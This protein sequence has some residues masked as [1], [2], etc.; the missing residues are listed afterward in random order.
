MMSNINAS[1]GFPLSNCKCHSYTDGILAIGQH[2][3]CPRSTCTGD[4]SS[5]NILPKPIHLLIHVFES[6]VAL[7]ICFRCH[8]QVVSSPSLPTPITPNPHFSQPPFSRLPFLLSLQ[9]PPQLMLALLFDPPSIGAL[10]ATCAR[11][12]IFDEITTAGVP[13]AGVGQDQGGVPETRTKSEQKKGRLGTKGGETGGRRGGKAHQREQ[14]GKAP[15]GK[16]HPGHAPPGKAHPGRAF[17]AHWVATP[18]F[19]FAL[20]A[21]TDVTAWCRDDEGIY[22]QVRELSTPAPLPHIR[23]IKP[24][25]HTHPNPPEPTRTHPYPLPTSP[26]SH[27]PP[28]IP[29]ATLSPPPGRN[30]CDWR[31][32]PAVPRRRFGDRHVLGLPSRWERRRQ[33]HARDARLPDGVGR[34]APGDAQEPLP[35][36][37]AH[38]LY[39]HPRGQREEHARARRGRNRGV[40]G[41]A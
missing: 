2:R 29:Y 7:S 21:G 34:L 25:P 20:R 3:I 5:P 35:R 18:G 4:W 6:C 12:D 17:L 33:E 41:Q 26:T 1:E 22:W 10:D 11:L 37:G 19:P 14:G 13:T 23:S 16:A 8:I 36:S 40:C 28:Y 9:L 31:F 27:T 30:S 39:A 15:P 32:P 24:S 38:R